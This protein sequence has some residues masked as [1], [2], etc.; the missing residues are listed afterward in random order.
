VIEDQGDP[1][2]VLRQML[3]RVEDSFELFSVSF[4][5]PMT[6][7]Q[8]SRAGTAAFRAQAICNNE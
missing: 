5:S 3:M 7:P 8:L 2:S 6:R 1:K 4:R